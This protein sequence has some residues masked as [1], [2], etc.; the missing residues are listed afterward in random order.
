MTM[1]ASG[2]AADVFC[3]PQL[4]TAHLILIYSISFASTN[5]P[6]LVVIVVHVN[7]SGAVSSSAI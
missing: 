4:L 3:V 2:S 5:I 7:V 6:A 1:M